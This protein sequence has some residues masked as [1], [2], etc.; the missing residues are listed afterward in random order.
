VRSALVVVMVVMTLALYPTRSRPFPC[1]TGEAPM[2]DQEHEAI[3]LVNQHRTTLGLTTVEPDHDL[4][5]AAA[6]KLEDQI[7]RGTLDHVEQSGR[8]LKNLLNDCG[9]D[10]PWAAELLA[11]QA[12]EPE[13]AVGGWR[14]SEPHHDILRAGVYTKAGVAARDGYWVFI[15]SGEG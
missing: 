12:P 6:I 4:A 13:V 5:Q 15:L 9:L 7:A 2:N 1:W 8:D 14:A 11:A 3:A 10:R